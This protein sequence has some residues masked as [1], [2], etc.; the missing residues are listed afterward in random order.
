MMVIP[1][2]V[3]SQYLHALFLKNQGNPGIIYFVY[4]IFSCY[5]YGLMK[6]K[7]GLIYLLPL[8]LLISCTSTTPGGKTR[9]TLNYFEYNRG[10][11]F[12]VT[13]DIGL[14][15]GTNS[16]DFYGIHL[17]D[18]SFFPDNSII[19]NAFLKPLFELRF[20]AALAAFTEPYYGYRFIHFFKKN[21][22][23][24]IGIEFIHHKIF[25]NDKD[26]NVRI[27]GI[28]QGN[29]I[30][31]TVPIKNHIGYFSVSHGINHVG[32][33][34]V[35]RM[36]LLPSRK[37]PDGRLQ[38]FVSFSLGPTIPHLELKLTENQ[39][40][41]DAYSFQSGFRNFGFGFGTGLRYK[42]WPHFG[43]YFEYKF[44][45]SHLHGM[46]LDNQDSEVIMDFFTHHLQWG[47]SIMF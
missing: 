4:N 25:L 18:D 33:T 26:Q 1:V 8:F 11:S 31:E 27:T 38:P 39:S 16:L 2:V 5:D 41:W 35:Y 10:K 9:M 7:I 13:T 23:F 14:R 40:N 47:L 44:T 28:Y 21:P 20:G 12:P 6:S 36:L 37:I 32:L 29:T 42:P 30:D 22:R 46:H 17:D 15:Y 3:N 43:F 45:Y 19:P 34:F 24:G